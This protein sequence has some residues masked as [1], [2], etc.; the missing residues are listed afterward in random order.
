M[1]VHL[2]SAPTAFQALDW[3]DLVLSDPAGTFFHTPAYLKVWWEE[4]GAGSLLLARV[5][6]G[7]VPVTACAFEIVDGALTFLGGFDVTDYMGPVG[8]PG[9]AE[10]ACKEL[11][12]A[13]VRLDSWDRADL[14]GLPLDSPWHS[15]LASAAE[16]HGL[17]VERHEDGVAPAIALPRSYKAYVGGLPAKLRHE[18]RRKQR[19]LVQEAGAFRITQSSP[20]SLPADLD[21]FIDLHRSSPGS[22]GRFMGA[23]MEIFFRR[24]GEAFLLPHVFHLAFME[25]GG[26]QAAGAIGFAFKNSFSLY[27][28][29]FDREFAPLSP[30]MVLVAELIRRAIET[31]RHSFDMLKGDLEYK[32]RFGSSPRPVGRLALVR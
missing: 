8:V 7:D 26:R 6:D 21:R 9:I 3:S 27:N 10:P 22:K 19:R 13:L 25:I 24:L 31:G 30:G 4:F 32:Y 20:E 15:A 5:T 2:A 18:I 16:A 1:H 28:S 23:G 14:R 12:D 11:L 29:A 17:H